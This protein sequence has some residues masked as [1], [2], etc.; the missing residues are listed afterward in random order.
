MSLAVFSITLDC[1]DALVVGSFWAAA[2]GRDLDT[3]PLPPTPF[4]ASIGRSGPVPARVM[5]ALDHDVRPR[6]QRVLR[7]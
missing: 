2:L 3:G 5:N 7:R 6:G 4:F 1:A